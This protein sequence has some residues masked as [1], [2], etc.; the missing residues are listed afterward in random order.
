VQRDARHQAVLA[1]AL[2]VFLEHG[3]AA[4]SIEEIRRRSGASV[5]SLYHRYGSKEGIAA[6]VYDDALAGYQQVFLATLE[7]DDTAEATVKAVVG[8]HL[9]WVQCHPDQAEFL[10][11]GH[12][13]ARDAVRE[14]NAAF[15][16]RVLAWLRP[17]I[18]AGELRD[19]PAH[20]LYALWLGP[21]QELARD[22]L[23]RG[24]RGSLQAHAQL[25]G[26]AAWRSLAT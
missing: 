3:V 21:S 10:F 26:D 16:A 14:R 18:A 7:R 9:R 11:T 20:A 22:W 5:G 25:L 19:V 8:A 4:A 24:R 12:A 15:F 1:A 13:A 17:R 6:A 23:A 2:D